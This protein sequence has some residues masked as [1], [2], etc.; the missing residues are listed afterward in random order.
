MGHILISFEVFYYWVY[1]WVSYRTHRRSAAGRA[2][3]C[4]LMDF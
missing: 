4:L 3:L 1:Y 2:I